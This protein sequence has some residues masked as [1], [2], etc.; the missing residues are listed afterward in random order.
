VSGG[1]PAGAAV[2]P[3]DTVAVLGALAVMQA[4]T[5]GQIRAWLA[6]HG[7]V[8][9]HPKRVSQRLSW[10]AMHDPPL[11]EV[12]ARD[13]ASA[14]APGVWR[15]TEAGRAARATGSGRLKPP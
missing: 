5:P 12:V 6:G 4:A 1:D 3:T 14:G 13:H 7:I 11:A 10:L 9:N 15:L 2:R 8:L